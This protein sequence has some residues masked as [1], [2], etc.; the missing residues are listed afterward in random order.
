M[1]Q[2]KQT[3]PICMRMQVQSL[4]WLSGLLWLWCRSEAAVPILPLAWEIAYAAGMTLIKAKNKQK[5]QTNA[6]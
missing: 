5:I 3:R 1:A 6:N 2:W 4:A